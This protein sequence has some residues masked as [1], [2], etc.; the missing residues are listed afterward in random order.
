MRL[1]GLTRALIFVRGDNPVPAPRRADTLIVGT[2]TRLVPTV[3][4]GMR[5]RR[6][7]RMATMALS[8][9]LPTLLAAAYYGFWASNRYVSETQMILTSDA[10]SS[11]GGL[12]SLGKSS[13]SGSSATSLLSLVG[14]SP[15]GDT[16]ANDQEVVI[17]YLQS[18]EAMEAADRAIGLRKLWSAGSIDP[19]SR[20]SPD[21]SAERFRRYYQSHVAV[22]SDPAD[23]VMELQVQAFS[24]A[25][26]RLIG[27]T[28]VRLGQ[29]KLNSAYKEMREDSLGFAR[30]EVTRAE[31]RLTAVNDKIRAFRNAHGDIDPSATAGAVGT[32]AGTT[33]GEL[34]GTEAQLETALSYARPDSPMVKALQARIAALKKQMAADRGLLA[35]SQTNK[36][37][38]NLLAEYEDLLLDQKFAE[39]VYTSALAFLDSRR[40]AT[41]H[42]Q[43]YLIDFIKP[44][45]PE[46]S[47]EPQSKRNVMLVFLA[48]FLTYLIGS[49]IISTL[50]E[51]AHH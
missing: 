49:L 2:G 27:K 29:E 47:I 15:G 39:A 32:V 24:P 48:S 12:S 9:G 5:T 10:G 50:R 36:N 20:M 17:N 38:A 4:D 6:R 22:S 43:T 23:P 25:D 28:L 33:F 16:T 37:Y 44:T 31:Q 8:V 26:A 40:A 30:S 18:I 3:Y 34:S 21:A 45:L 51:H 19:L 35:G 42:Q 11:G 1:R 41:V 13:S 7:R 46:E 14:I